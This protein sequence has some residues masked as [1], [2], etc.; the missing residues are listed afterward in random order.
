MPISGRTRFI[1]VA[2]FYGISGAASNE[3]KYRANEELL[4]MAVGRTIEVGVE[5]YLLCGHIN[6][7]PMDS[8]T[9]RVAVNAG[10]PVDI[11]HEWAAET[12]ENEQG[13]SWK[14]PENTT[15]TDPREDCVGKVS[16]SFLPIRK[17]RAP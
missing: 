11:G 7:D 13:E 4:A 1:N 10:L 5:P 14:I 12:E 2:S 3:K 8:A 17:L 16:M 15:G 9:V 6:V